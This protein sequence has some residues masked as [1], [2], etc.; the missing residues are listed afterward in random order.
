MRS[1]VLLSSLVVLAS[2]TAP[3]RAAKPEIERP[4]G[5]PQADGVVHTLRAIPEACARLQGRFTGDPKS[6]YHFAPVRSSASC[7]PRARFVDPQRAKPSEAGGWKL[8]D[9]IRVPSTACPGLQAVVEVWRKPVDA[10]PPALD[11]QG[12]ARLYLQDAKARAP[13]AAA[14]VGQFTA[15]V[16]VEGRCGA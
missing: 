15:T 9:V 14:S 7:Q 12:R 6:P 4:A 8:N 2:L 16:A 5:T 11:A 10:R 1:V 13:A 3:A